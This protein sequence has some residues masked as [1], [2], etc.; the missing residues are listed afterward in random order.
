MLELLKEIFNEK[1]QI[2]KPKIKIDRYEYTFDEKKAKVE[3][4]YDYLRR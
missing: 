2:E 1:L 3:Y 4:P